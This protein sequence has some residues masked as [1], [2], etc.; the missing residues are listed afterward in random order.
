VIISRKPKL[1]FPKQSN[2]VFHYCELLDSDEYMWTGIILRDDIEFPHCKILRCKKKVI[3]YRKG[4][5]TS[6]HSLRP[7]KDQKYLMTDVGF[8]TK[9]CKKKLVGQI[10]R[11][12]EY[13][14][15]CFVIQYND[16]FFTNID[17]K[18][19]ENTLLSKID[20]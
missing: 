14:P 7:S 8:S 16:F 20:I 17:S 19:D 4:S 18:I 2:Q 6:L 10:I 12:D 3:I 13:E 9:Y 5:F 1:F 11:Y 15:F